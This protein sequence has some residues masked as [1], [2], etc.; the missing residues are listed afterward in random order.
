MVK[1]VPRSGDLVWI[2]VGPSSPEGP[3]KRPAVVLSPYHYN[4]K[5]ELALFLPVTSKINGYPFEVAI[6]SPPI[7]G[8]VLC[9]QV[10]SLDWRASRV[11]Y[12]AVLKESILREIT[13]KFRALLP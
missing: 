1:Y 3:K 7:E 5:V 4:K 13:D 10:R 8:V 6:N 12:I 11:K 2:E 9:D